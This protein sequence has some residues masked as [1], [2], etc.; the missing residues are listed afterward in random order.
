MCIALHTADGAV[1]NGRRWA[2][3]VDAVDARVLDHAI[4][5]V[6]DIG[7]G[8]GRHVAAL[9]QHGRIVLGIDVTPA[10]I[11]MA[12]RRN[13]PVLERGVFDA[14]PARG[15]WGSALLLDGNIGIGGD[16][17]VLLHRVR[18]LVRPGGV[19]LVELEAVNAVRPPT[20]ARLV[21]DN[22][23]GPW[24]AWARVS[25][26]EIDGLAI[27]AG[28]RVDLRWRDGAR[29]FARLVCE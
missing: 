17:V 7:C 11:A 24:F 6:L 9:A 25:V 13:V 3:D 27:S 2:L 15:R 21:V 12:R 28:F 4:E 23:P 14:V 20:A 29:S 22:D 1:T 16:P 26:D 10:A 5:P 18:S 19:V 8:P